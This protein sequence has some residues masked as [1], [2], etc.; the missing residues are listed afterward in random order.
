MS[1]Q[2]PHWK[3]AYMCMFDPFHDP[4]MSD[5]VVPGG[6]RGNALCCWAEARFG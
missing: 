2:L 6:N 1:F 5:F 4:A 3:A